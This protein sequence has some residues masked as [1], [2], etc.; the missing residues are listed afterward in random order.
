MPSS[1]SCRFPA[2]KLVCRSSINLNVNPQ[3]EDFQ[4]AHDVELAA[5]LNRL[6][7]EI[8]AKQTKEMAEAKPYEIVKHFDADM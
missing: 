4:I 8:W 6:L 7:D 2:W 5:F 1:S 3:Y